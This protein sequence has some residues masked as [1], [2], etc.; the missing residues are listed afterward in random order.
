MEEDKFDS[1][2]LKMLGSDGKGGD[3]HA[4]LR[5]GPS[6]GLCTLGMAE[7]SSRGQEHGSHGLGVL[8]QPPLHPGRASWQ[9]REPPL[10]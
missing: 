7:G 2:A 6:T 8:W 5:D 4:V 3:R 10:P 9:T 1:M